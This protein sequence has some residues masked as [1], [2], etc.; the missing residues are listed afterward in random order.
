MGYWIA[1]FDIVGVDIA[2]QPNFPFRFEQADALKYPLA[3]FDAVHMGPPCQAYS[4]TRH[5]NALDPLW[6]PPPKLIAPLRQRVL[7]EAPDLPY[8]IENVEDAAPYMQNPRR[9]C[10]SSLGIR[11]RRHRLFETNWPLTTPPCDHAWQDEHK[12]YNIYVGKS[13]TDGLGHRDRG[14]SL[15]F[16]SVAMGI[17]WMTEPEINESIPPAYTILIGDQ[18]KWRLLT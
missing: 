1:G 5:R 12:P 16:K 8:V 11:V 14:G 9:L 18:L 2:P 13:R 15:Y 6:T 10:G 4:R 7:D 17:D 3:G